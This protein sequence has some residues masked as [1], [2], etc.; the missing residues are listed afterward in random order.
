MS[1][2]L[3]EWRLKPGDE[4]GNPRAVER[5]LG[6]HGG[7]PAYGN[8]CIGDRVGSDAESGMEALLLEQVDQNEIP[9]FVCS[10]TSLLAVIVHPRLCFNRHFVDCAISLVG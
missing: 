9:C 10:F 2:G 1:K 8:G 5:V 3:G 6:E 7:R 4:N